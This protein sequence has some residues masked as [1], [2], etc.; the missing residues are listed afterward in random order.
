MKLSVKIMQIIITKSI[1][2]F[3]NVSIKKHFQNLFK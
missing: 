2:S 1:E 3:L